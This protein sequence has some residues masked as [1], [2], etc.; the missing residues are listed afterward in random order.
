[1]SQRRK[2]AALLSADAVG[3]SRLM[4]DD[5]QATFSTLKAYRDI[6]AQHITAHEGRVVDSPGDALLAEFP[7]AVEAV[8]SAVEIQRELAG[9]NASLPEHRKMHFRIGLNLGDVTEQ[10][11]ALYGDGVN[12]AAR[13]EALAESGGICV[14]GTVYDQVEGKLPVAFKFAGEQSAKNIAKPV[15]AYHALLDFAEKKEGGTPRPHAKHLAMLIGSVLLVGAVLAS[16]QATRSPLAP[17]QPAPETALKLPED[18]SIAVMPFQNMS[19]DPEDEWF[20]DGMTETLITDLS[21]LDRL[22]VIARSST[23]AYK[24]KPADVRRVG[25]ELGVR[26]VLEGSVQ[27]T[28]ERLRVN[29]QLVEAASARHLWAERYDR[30]LDDLFE[31]Q[32]DI[33]QKI[34][35]ELD[36]KLRAGEQARVWRKSTGNREAYDLLM[37]GVAF[38]EKYTQENAARA[39]ELFQQALDLDPKFA[40]ALVKLG[41][42]YCN[43]GDAGWNRD[44]KES[45]VK[46]VELGRKA[47]AIDPSLGQ[48]YALIA[49]S[50]SSLEKHAEALDAAEKA[51]ALSPNEAD[52]LVLA[53]WVFAL[54]GRAQVA[55]SLVERA[56]R[57]NPVTPYW[58]FG[59]LGDSLL[60]ANRVD[61]A[62][63][64]QRKCVESAP[65]FVW[66]DLGLT[67]T[68]A[69]ARKMQEATDQVTVIL[70]IDPKIT[71][72]D[73][74][75][76]RSLSTPKDRARAAS[77]L[78]RAG[79][80]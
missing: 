47:I 58:Y 72:E 2:L 53:G 10:D 45:Y 20:S 34:V 33:V 36:V 6:F 55:V 51:V 57:L 23:F 25:R 32:D 49:N 50:L 13:L 38:S 63:P 12:I 76:V 62:L 79:L 31:I 17:A 54:N 70:R 73:N 39:R 60:F 75:Y 56:I 40:V 67:V 4:G 65:E 59:A 44:P 68:Y 18:P 43:E 27:R 5:E 71:A 26:Y 48:A 22:F 37:R 19:G 21:T 61:E 46:A 1:M 30:K 77:A 8:S 9:R 74:V 69:E 80:P 29:A 14:S 64:A 66:C 3:Y 15:R 41:W 52:V 7:S 35:T 11:G 16:W 42:V 78:R 28:S 24:G